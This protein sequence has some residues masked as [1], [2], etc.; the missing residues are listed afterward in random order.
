MT[1]SDL[2]R[3]MKNFKKE[4]EGL[5]SDRLTKLNE[6]LSDTV[7]IARDI[8]MDLQSQNFKRERVEYT[9]LGASGGNKQ[10]IHGDGDDEEEDPPP[11]FCGLWRFKRK[12][13]KKE[14]PARDTEIKTTIKWMTVTAATEE[15]SFDDMSAM[16]GAL[17]N[18]AIEIGTEL[19]A[20]N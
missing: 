16:T 7:D 4:E 1:E 13:K 9:L 11:K 18:L 6:T 5:D 12:F 8:K 14:K 20:K 17:K 19:D 10:D 2:E 3:F 15:Q